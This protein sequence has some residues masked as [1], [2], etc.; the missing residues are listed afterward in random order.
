MERFWSKVDIRGPND[1]W[2][3]TASRNQPGYGI[4]SLRHKKNVRAHR[5]AWTLS[6]GSIPPGKLVLHQCH[7]PGCVNPRHL[8]LGTHSDNM[9]Q[10]VERGTVGR[11]VPWAP[12]LPGELNPSAKLTWNDVREIRRLHQTGKIG[13]RRLARMFRVGETA[14]RHINLFRSWKE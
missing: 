6:V 4:F 8:Q 11:R 14:I 2:E 9:A 13:C 12:P 10:A 1:C 7:N 3:W 5:M